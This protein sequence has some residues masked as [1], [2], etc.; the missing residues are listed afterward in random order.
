[1]RERGAQRPVFRV[2]E[3]KKTGVSNPRA[4]SAARPTSINVLISFNPSTGALIGDK[5]LQRITLE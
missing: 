5:Y 4:R 3:P 2:Q 1:M